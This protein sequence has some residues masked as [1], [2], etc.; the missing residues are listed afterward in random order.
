MSE[1]KKFSKIDH[2]A[3]KIHLILGPMYAGKTTELIRLRNRAK[4][5]GKKCLIIKYCKDIRY[6]IEKLSTHDQLKIDA[7]ISEGNNLRKTLLKIPNLTDYDCLFID[8][9]QF[10]EDAA[11]VCDQLANEG[12]EVIVCGLQ[13]NFKRQTFKVIRNF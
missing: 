13:S 9:I 10:Y 6:D 2:R 5:A 12:Y 3:G 4:S 11:T 1:Y 7:L 8:E